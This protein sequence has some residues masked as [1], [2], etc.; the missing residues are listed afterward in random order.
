[1]LPVYALGC[2]GNLKVNGGRPFGGDHWTPTLLD[3]DHAGDAG[4]DNAA[5]GWVQV[6]SQS[7]WRGCNRVGMSYWEAHDTA[8]PTWGGR[9]VQPKKG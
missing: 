5:R 3:G 2:A 8:D 9:T 4:C 6:A 7:G 1:M